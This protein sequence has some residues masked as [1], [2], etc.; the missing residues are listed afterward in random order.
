[1]RGNTTPATV[2]FWGAALAAVALQGGPA[3]A[4]SLPT[5]DL[6]AFTTVSEETAPAGE[7]VPIPSVAD[8]EAITSLPP[9]SNV[10]REISIPPD[11]R[12]YMTSIVG[13]SFFVV[14]ADNSPESCLTAGGAVGAA[15]E[16]SDG[17]IRLELE[18]RYRDPIEQTYLG[19]NRSP[20][21]L[22][23]GPLPPKPDL[24]GTMQA[25][26]YGGWSTLANVWRDFRL[27]DSLDI[28]GG[29][30]IGAAGFQTSFQQID[31]TPPAPANYAYRTAYAWQIG[32]GGIWN[33]NE[34]VAV[35]V[36]YR[37][38][39]TGWTINVTDVAYGFLRNEIL[40]SVRIYEPFRGLW[41]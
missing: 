3:A 30:G 40:L 10:A 19:F 41:R 9:T 26:A 8:H 16:R 7:L 22:G 2:F 18:G 14:T 25:K 38:F 13:G 32:V 11:R 37:F 20:P 6:G 34:R 24:I 1:M 29:G 31:T 27:T 12:F 28:Y 33:V 15:L 4:E 21:R 23:P 35:D 5:L 17:R 36:S 39:N